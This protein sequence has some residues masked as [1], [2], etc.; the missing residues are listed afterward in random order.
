MLT[1]SCMN[2]YNITATPAP[3]CPTCG[4][5]IYTAAECSIAQCLHSELM[6]TFAFWG[7][8]IGNAVVRPLQVVQPTTIAP[9]PVATKTKVKVEKKAKFKK[10]KEKKVKGKGKAKEDA[11]N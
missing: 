8:S 6:A 3:Y 9:T 7:G 2:G 10:D 1:S 5:Q 4:S 11:V